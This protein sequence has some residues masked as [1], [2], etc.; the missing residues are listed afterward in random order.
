MHYL[1]RYKDADDQ[2]KLLGMLKM[3]RYLDPRLAEAESDTSNSLVVQM[4]ALELGK[5]CIVL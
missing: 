4:V 1:Y 2:G 5:Y 3:C